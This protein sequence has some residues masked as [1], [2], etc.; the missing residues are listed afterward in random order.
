ML[1][2][3]Y[4]HYRAS[5][6]KVSCDPSE[7][8]FPPWRPLTSQNQEWKPG[9]TGPQSETGPARPPKEDR[10][11]P[12]RTTQ[13]PGAL[14]AAD[15]ADDG[16][17]HLVHLL[18]HLGD[19]LGELLLLLHLHLRLEERLHLGGGVGPHVLLSLRQTTHG[20]HTGIGDGAEGH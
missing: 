11:R 17:R 12:V 8:L 10:T 2:F 19:E 20:A 13:L 3:S 16:H 9:Q 7:V 1:C 6:P 18:H 5:P 15:V 4:F 14:S